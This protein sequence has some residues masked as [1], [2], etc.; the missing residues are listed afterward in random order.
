MTVLRGVVKDVGQ[1]HFWAELSA[2]GEDDFAAEIG[3]KLVQDNDRPLL[4][5]GALF[6]WRIDGAESKI[7]FERLPDF[8]HAE[9]EAARAR[10]DQIMRDL[11]SN[12]NP[13]PGE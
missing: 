11:F 5:A 3:V 12:T 4:K 7:S 9:I 1:D 6:T 2:D 8:T 10:A 13:P